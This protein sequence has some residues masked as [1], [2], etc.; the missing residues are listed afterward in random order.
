[1]T[2]ALVEL[3]AE[4]THGY[5]GADLFALL[6]LVC[7]KARQRQL[8][9]KGFPVTPNNSTNEPYSSHLGDEKEA[10][11]PSRLV[12][13]EPDIMSSLQEIRP[14]AMREVFLE[15]PKIRWTD[16][17]GQHEI[18]KRLQQAVERPLKVRSITT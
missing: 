10:E 8:L 5:V 1:L 14:T 3:L 17:G 12:I 7:R 13:Q 2:D 9:E 6:Q 15:T 4:K 16:I 18:K 11:M